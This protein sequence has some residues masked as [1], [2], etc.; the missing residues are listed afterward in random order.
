MMQTAYARTG[1]GPRCHMPRAGLG[2]K[3]RDMLSDVTG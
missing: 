1:T 3:A 2:R